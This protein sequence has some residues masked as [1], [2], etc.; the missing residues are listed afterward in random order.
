LCLTGPAKPYGLGQDVGDIFEALRAQFGLTAH[1]ARVQLQGEILRLP[2]E[3][4][5]P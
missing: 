5:Q 1:N 4:T 3:S 2:C